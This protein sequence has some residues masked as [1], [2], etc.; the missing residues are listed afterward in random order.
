MA[1]SPIEGTWSVLQRAQRTIVVV[2][3]VE[4]VRLIEQ[5]ELGV[6]DRW[7]HF[8]NEVATEVLPKHGGRLVKSLG[9]GLMLEFASVPP[10]VA[11][12]LDL[13]RRIANYNSD[14][15]REAA[16][17]LR[18]GAHVADVV[19]DNLDVYGSG[20]NLAA[21][22]GTLAGPGEIVVSAL[23][24]DRLVPGLD[25]DVE[26]LGDC[27]VKHLTTPI[28]A[29]RIG[30]VGTPAERRVGERAAA[31]PLPS[32]AVIPFEDSA[33]PHDVTGDWIAD[34]VIARLSVHPMLRVISRLSTAAVRA[35][36]GSV[37]QVGAWLNAVY[38]V[39]GRVR[40]AGAAVLL[41]VEIA[42]ARTA[43]VLWA[44][45]LRSSSGDIIDPDSELVERLA[46]AITSTVVATETRRAGAMPL[47][48][49][50]SFSLQLAATALMHRASGGEFARARDLFEHLI[51]RHPRA[52]APRAWLALWYVLRVTRGLV[53]DPIQEAAR[54]LDL[55]RRAIDA[56]PQCSLALA[57]EG[58]V[59]CHM[60]RDLDAANERLEAALAINPSESLAWLFR[61]VVQGFRGEGEAA[62][63]SADRALA[64]S[65]LDPIRHYY[66]SLAS[67]ASLAACRLDR[68]IELAD[69]SLRVNRNHV[70]TLR[71]L[72]IAQSESGQDDAARR[73]VL[74]VLE[75]EPGLTLRGYLA[76]APRGGE[77]TR[78]RYAQALGRAGV[79]LG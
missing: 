64:L 32:V 12:A 31:L 4:S 17:L 43:E 11:A 53:V 18:I 47:P 69:R 5:D 23:V 2:D 56:D 38:V 21:R 70:P 40:V 34:R 46:I 35:R 7:R 8:V 51:E 63:E 61:C 76:R 62:V 73:T 9:D 29:F 37:E 77:A 74:R 30:A 14:E 3:V 55:T 52:S 15:V 1:T 68:A 45:Q 48:S 13:Q 26:D 41:A 39:S 78:E 19:V 50:E 66:D 20:V 67:S 25:A 59:Q 72:A 79:P 65:P 22:L 58:F 57:A 42:D 6:I 75:L 10:A 16:I 54:A 24:R 28:R 44:E 71:V 27:Y 33:S 36:G 49:L 60:R